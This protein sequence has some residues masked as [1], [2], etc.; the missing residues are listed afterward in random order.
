MAFEELNKLVDKALIL[1]KGY[2]DIT[3]S[4]T[5]TIKIGN[6]NLPKVYAGKQ[7]LTGDFTVVNNIKDKL[8]CISSFFHI[9]PEGLIRISTS[10]EDSSG[11]RVIG[12]L[13]DNSHPICISVKNKR[14]E[15]GRNWAI[16]DFYETVDFPIMDENGNIILGLGFGHKETRGEREIILFRLEQY[17]YGFNIMYVHEVI[18]IPD[19]IVG[20]SGNDE[21]VIGVFSLQGE[22]IPLINTKKVFGFGSG[23]DIDPK[24]QQKVLLMQLDTKKYGIL[25]DKV[26]GLAKYDLKEIQKIKV[27][28]M[29]NVSTNLIDGVV[30]KIKSYTNVIILHADI[31]VQIA[32]KMKNTV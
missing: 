3:I 2:G 22:V 26:I 29:D 6:F 12:T 7:L 23:T 30:V 15:I 14:K 19:N 16:N 25:V 5:E 13:L 24:S 4:E 17:I 8:E 28:G 10:L 31:L 1:I 20:T 21:Y 11:N 9:V 18:N 27:S 32:M